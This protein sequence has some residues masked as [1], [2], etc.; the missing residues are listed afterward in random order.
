MPLFNQNRPP[1]PFTLQRRKSNLPGQTT[2]GGKPSRQGGTDTLQLYPLE[3]TPA[4]PGPRAQAA[5]QRR[6]PQRQMRPP[7]SSMN[8]GHTNN[9]ASPR[10][11]YTMAPPV[12]R[13]NTAHSAPQN[14]F[15]QTAQAHPR[16]SNAPTPMPQHA[17]PGAPSRPRAQ[18]GLQPQPPSPEQ[19]VQQFQRAN[20]GLPDGVRYEPLDENTMRLLRENGHLPPLPQDSNPEHAAAA[21]M[22]QA[23]NPG[24]MAAA[25]QAFNPG[26]MAAPPQASSPG[27][28]AAVP[29]PQVPNLGHMATASQSSATTPPPQSII[30]IIEELIQDERNA[31][32]FYSHLS[33]SAAEKSIAAALADIA[34]DNTKHTH[35]FTRILANQFN[36]KFVPAE[37]EI[38][39]ALELKDALALAL[40]EENKTLRALAELSEGIANAESEKIIQRIINKKIMNYNQLGRIFAFV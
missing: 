19:A 10:P 7:V 5:N 16:H 32:I 17:P 23:S 27:H 30:N 2:Q 26:H 40:E 11:E 12:M 4:R 18:A 36:S 8:H 29:V 24:S 15:G 1:N 9:S 14:P 34:N 28:M 33:K 6:Q 25:P 31:N 38:N 37:A 13:G 20:K 21:P 35:S 39:T 3:L 22:P